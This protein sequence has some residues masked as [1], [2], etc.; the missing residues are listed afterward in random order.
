MLEFF[1]FSFLAGKIEEMSEFV[2][3][4]RI[5]LTCS[6]Y[7]QT[8]RLGLSLAPCRAAGMHDFWQDPIILRPIQSWAT[9][10]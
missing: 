2:R 9:G 5:G 10:F 1:H 3:F 6:S 8:L 7:G 4:T